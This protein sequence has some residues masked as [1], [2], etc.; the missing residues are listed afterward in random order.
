MVHMPSLRAMC[1]AGEVAEG[2]NILEVGPGLGALTEL[3][4]EQGANVT[5]VEYDQR[6]IASLKNI[7]NDSKLKIVEGDILKFDLTTMPK[8]YKVVANIPY[9][10]TS[11]L[12]RD[13]LESSNPPKLI[14]LLVQRE[15]AERISA[16]PGKLSILGV[17]TQFYAQTQLKDEVPA[18]FF[19]PQPK[20]DSQIIQLKVRSKPLFDVDTNKFFRLVKSGFSEK[21]KKLTNSLSAGLVIEKEQA[22]ELVKS[23]GLSENIRAQ[24]LSLQQWFQLYDKL[25]N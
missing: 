2:D 3:L 9:Y 20:V 12:L 18:K 6:L 14:A 22:R 15:V 4:L 11:K 13:L 25:Y 1:Q 16:P 19:E 23:L 10:L 8:G 24:E 21:R 5:A 7:F 17:S